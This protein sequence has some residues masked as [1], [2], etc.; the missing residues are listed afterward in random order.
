M[1]RGRGE[2]VEVRKGRRVT[3]N[4]KWTIVTWDVRETNKRLLRRVS[5]RL[6]REK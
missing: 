2:R 1:R 3:R 6:K 5:E 4:W